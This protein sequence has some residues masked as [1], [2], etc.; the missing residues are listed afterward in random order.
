M[1]MAVKTEKGFQ[2]ISAQFRGHVSLPV[3]VFEPAAH[4]VVGLI[5]VEV[6]GRKGHRRGTDFRHYLTDEFQHGDEGFRERTCFHLFFLKGL[7]VNPFRESHCTVT[8]SPA[9]T[10]RIVVGQVLVVQRLVTPR[11]DN[12]LTGRKSQA[13]KLIL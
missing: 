8:P 13:I 10:Q 3:G 11:A 2:F 5:I 12:F 1:G 6:T 4:K 7:T 9:A